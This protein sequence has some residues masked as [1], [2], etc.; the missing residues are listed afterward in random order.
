MGRTSGFRE[1]QVVDVG[2]KLHSGRAAVVPGQAEGDAAELKGLQERQVDDHLLIGIASH[3]ERVIS[4]EQIC[5]LVRG[6]F[7]QAVAASLHE[8]VVD[9]NR[10]MGAGHDI[11]MKEAKTKRRRAANFC[12]KL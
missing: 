7:V 4:A 1:T 3:A 11:E 6:G 12:R 10:S 5:V 9:A 2:E 8:L